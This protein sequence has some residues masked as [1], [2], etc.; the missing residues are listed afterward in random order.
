MYAAAALLVTG[1]LVVLAP[2]SASASAHG[3]MMAPGSRTWMCYK[4]GR[5]ATGEIKPINPAC[6]AAVAKSGA[7]SLYH[8]FA[9]LRSDGA[10]GG[11]P[12]GP[13]PG[14]WLRGIRPRSL[15]KTVG[16]PRRRLLAFRRPCERTRRWYP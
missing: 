13:S 6:A 2:S 9:V 12:R 11:G 5:T 7:T 16:G 1:V 10:A 8:W 15:R 3:T 4:D 14:W